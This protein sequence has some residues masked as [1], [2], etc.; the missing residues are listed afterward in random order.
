MRRGHF[1][2]RSVLVQDYEE[3]PP[4]SQKDVVARVT[5]LSTMKIPEDT[6]ID[7]KQ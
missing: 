4:R 2:C 3:I 5:L 1:R 6:M 7:A